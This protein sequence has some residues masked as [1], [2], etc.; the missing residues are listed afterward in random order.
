MLILIDREPGRVGA[1][2]EDGGEKHLGASI[3]TNAL[4][5]ISVLK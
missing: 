1:G 5:I 3:R 4:L 2:Y